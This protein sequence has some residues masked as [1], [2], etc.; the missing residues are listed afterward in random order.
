MC[1][2]TYRT[3]RTGVIEGD[4]LVFLAALAVW[5]AFATYLLFSSFIPFSN[6]TIAIA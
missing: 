4:K 6:A 1:A 5:I 3:D 2:Q